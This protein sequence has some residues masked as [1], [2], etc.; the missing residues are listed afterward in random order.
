MTSKSLEQETIALFIDETF[1]KINVIKKD[2]EIYVYDYFEE[3]KRQ[4]DMRRENL[5]LEIDE[6][7]DEMIQ[8]INRIQSECRDRVKQINFNREIKELNDMLDELNKNLDQSIKLNSMID[9]REKIGTKL[10][11]FRMNL[12]NQKEYRFK[13]SD[14]KVENIFGCFFSDIKVIFHFNYLNR[15][16]EN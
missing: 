13:V 8:K 11:H 2:P 4:V 9:L 1:R 16:F 15:Y 14:S 12:T 5:K 7:S 3:I 10:D 6:Y